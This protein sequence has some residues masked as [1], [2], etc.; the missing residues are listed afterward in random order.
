MTVLSSMPNSVYFQTMWGH[1]P[2]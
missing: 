1:G 2:G